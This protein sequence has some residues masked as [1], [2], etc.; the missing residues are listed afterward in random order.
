V[1]GAVTRP[2]DVRVLRAEERPD[3]VELLQIDQLRVGIR[4][5]AERHDLSVGP[6]LSIVFGLIAMLGRP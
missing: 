6:G 1:G 3:T 2:H 5:S 4:L